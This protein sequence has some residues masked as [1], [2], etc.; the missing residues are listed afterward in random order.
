MMYWGMRKKHPAEAID[1]FQRA[2]RLDPTLAGPAMMWM[3]LIR[4]RE[5]NPVEAEALYKAALAA[6]NPTSIEAETTM[7][8]YARFLKNQGRGD[9]GK[10]TL[11]QAAIVRR[12]LEQ[13][14]G[15]ISSSA[16]R[17]GGGVSAPSVLYK[18]DP[19]YTE[20]A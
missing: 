15:P 7:E 6:E 13:P 18:V 11:D 16:L 19:E 3:A 20:E 5:E 10:A 1:F 9:E 14:A 8:L 12:A 4:E 17:V 2:Q